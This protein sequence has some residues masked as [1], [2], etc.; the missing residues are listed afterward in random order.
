MTK[1]FK[2]K[3]FNLSCQNPAARPVHIIDLPGHPRLRAKLDEFLPQVRGIVFVVD[4][5]DFTT[6]IRSSAES[7]LLEN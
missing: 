3:F 1:G 6:Q 2:V 5:L 4:A 7:E